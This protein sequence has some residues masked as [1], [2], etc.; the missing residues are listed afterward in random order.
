MS[1]PPASPKIYHITH[2]E[3]LASI[4]A[5]GY[6]Y[7]DATMVVRGGPSVTIGMDHIKRDRFRCPV[8][9]H[10]G[11]TVADYVPFNF[12]PRS[13]MLYLIY[14]ANHPRLAYRGGEGPIVHLQADLHTVVAWADANGVRWTFTAAN[15]R[16]AYAEFFAD[17][18][19]LVRI[20]WEAVA[21]SD[22][23]S[24][25]VKEAKQAEFLIRD[26]FPWSFVESVG[27]RSQTV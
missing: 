1:T 14:M 24:E 7:S 4:V 11:D 13:V 19:D 23:R 17:R 26:R 18:A 22:F 2:V 16:A 10:S 12:C 27:V 3:N 25:A 5:E 8:T 6:V 15:A 9:C 20:P 21:N